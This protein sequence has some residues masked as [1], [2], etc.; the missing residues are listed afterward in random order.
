MK[1]MF[2][3]CFNLTNLNLSSFNTE[4]VTDMSEMFY[5]CGALTSLDVTNFNTANV[6]TMY[7]M[8]MGCG[9]LTSLDVSHFNTANVTNMESMFADCSGLKTLDLSSFNTAKVEYTQNMF[10]DCAELT[11]IFAGDEWTMAAVTWGPGMFSNCYKLVG[12][13]GTTYDADHIDET[14]AHIDEGTANPGYFT[15]SGDDP[16]VAPA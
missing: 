12:G 6:T 7:N 3:D 9:S 16:Y 1:L 15:R 4:N 11:T 5:R 2:G 13:K 8:F 10:R 14:Y